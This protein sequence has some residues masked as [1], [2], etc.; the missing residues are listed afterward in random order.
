MQAG[1]VH[2]L[3]SVEKTPPPATVDSPMRRDPIFYSLFQR[4]PQLLFELTG[5]TPENAQG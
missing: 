4:R 5:L 2:L 1:F 3:T